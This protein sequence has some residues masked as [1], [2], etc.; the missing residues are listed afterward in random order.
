MNTKEL[1]I[2]PVW[3]GAFEIVDIQSGKR[4]LCGNADKVGERMEAATWPL[5][6]PAL[7]ARKPITIKIEYGQ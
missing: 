5:I 3:D 4:M 2:N 1:H 7:K 6:E